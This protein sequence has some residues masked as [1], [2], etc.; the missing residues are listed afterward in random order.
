MKG[1]QEYKQKIAN[2][3]DD[4][5]QYCII[6]T[7][8][9]YENYECENYESNVIGNCREYS[10]TLNINIWSVVNGVINYLF[11]LFIV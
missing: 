8:T 2:K 5:G 11:K 10:H 3:M 4:Y 1:Y 9:E 7:T 6:D